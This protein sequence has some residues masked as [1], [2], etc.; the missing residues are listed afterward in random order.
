MT[1]KGKSILVT[2]GT[3]F[4]GSSLIE[5]LVLEHDSRVRIGVRNFAKA[6][7][8]AC[9]PVELVSGD[10]T[11]KSAVENALR[12]CDVVFHCA[13]DFGGGRSGQRRVGIQ[14]TRNVSEAVLREGVA[15]MVYVST[16]AVYSPW[17]DG[18]LTESSPWP[19]RGNVYTQVKRTAERLVI[20]L[21]RRRHLPVVV[22]QPTIVYGPFSEHWTINPVN[23]LKTGL[24]PLVNGGEGFCNAVYIDDL[25]DAMILAATRPDV[26]GETFLISAEQPV[27]WKTYYDVLQEAIGVKATVEMSVQELEKLV[28]ERARSSK[29]IPLLMSWARDP[30]VFSQLARL[31]LA[32]TSLKFLRRCLPDRQWES[33]KSGIFNPNG[34]SH[35][36]LHIPDMSLHQSRTRV[37]IDKAQERLGYIP[38]FDFERGMDLTTHFI[39]WANLAPA[40]PTKTWQGD[41][42][43][44][45]D[46]PANRLAASHWTQ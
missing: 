13:Y 43:V 11:D 1:L 46:E 41:L 24:V 2:G 31:P 10:V 27:T 20:D 8:I 32:Q 44:Q 9:L 35:P 15:R 4:I 33:V 39:R 5:K 28:R 14:G 16:F 23:Q 25:V 29:T 18:E 21:Y 36:V 45:V 7:R 26:L 6:S 40:L 19:S 38:K 17:P 3:G 37:C 12:G 22:V 30:K 42:S 34:H